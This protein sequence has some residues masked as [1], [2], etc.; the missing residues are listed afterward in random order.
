VLPALV[1]Y[2]L[3][4]ALILFGFVALFAAGDVQRY[5]GFSLGVGAGLALLLLNWLFRLGARDNSARDEEEA[6]RDYFTEHG[7]W[8][9]E[10]P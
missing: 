6:A 4:G 1:R 2:G 10:R 7:H 5:E 9:D 8:P 3:P